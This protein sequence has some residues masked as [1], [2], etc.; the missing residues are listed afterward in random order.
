MNLRELGAR[1]RLHAV[2]GDD[3]GIAQAPA[4]I[5]LGDVLGSANGRLWVV[6]ALIDLGEPG[7]ALDALA[8]VEPNGR[9]A[10]V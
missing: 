8:E 10:S 5:E 6:S 1:V 2:D 3:L 4:P 7:D 9:A